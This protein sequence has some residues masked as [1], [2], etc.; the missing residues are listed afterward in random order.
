MAII[1]TRVEARNRRAN[2]HEKTIASSWIWEEITHPTMGGKELTREEALQIIKR[3]GL[4]LVHNV[5]G[6]GQIYDRP[7][8]PFYEQYKGFYSNRR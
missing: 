2:E 5:P 4:I 6:V 7:D 1:K 3:D 8:E